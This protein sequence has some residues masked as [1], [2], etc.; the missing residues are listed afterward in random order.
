MLGGRIFLGVGRSF[1]KNP[2]GFY[3]QNG[4]RSARSTFH[5]ALPLVASSITFILPNAQCK[6]T[7]APRIYIDY[8]SFLLSRK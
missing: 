4:S 2:Y 7:P 1:L 8:S 5:N 3:L 6:K